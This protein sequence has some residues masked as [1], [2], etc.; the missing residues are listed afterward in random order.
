MIFF[1][2]YIQQMKIQPSSM[3]IHPQCQE[4]EG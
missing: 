3:Q 1:L 4:L 2:R